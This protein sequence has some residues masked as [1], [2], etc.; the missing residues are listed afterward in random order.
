MKITIT[1]ELDDDGRMPRV[2]VRQNGHAEK[3]PAEP[4]A[5][6][7]V[8]VADVA[9][10]P[11]PAE[12]TPDKPTTCKP[13]SGPQF[14]PGFLAIVRDECEPFT[15]RSLAVA[16]GLKVEDVTQRLNRLSHHGWVEQP[17][18]GLW[19]KTKTWAQKQ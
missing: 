14:D 2:H 9:P 12:S 8:K 15:R 18:P 3:A 5:P 11:L 19:R 4:K 1:I 17:A 13:N 6:G 16:S 10:P 7:T